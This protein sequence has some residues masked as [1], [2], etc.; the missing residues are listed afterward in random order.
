MSDQQISIL[1]WNVGGI[2]YPSTG[3]IKRK[4]FMTIIPKPG[5][6][7]I[8]EHKMITKFCEKIGTMGLR[9]GKTLWNGVVMNLDI[10]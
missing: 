4:R 1:T 9:R 5:L 2:S 7:F 10:G 3:R 8:Q 6:V